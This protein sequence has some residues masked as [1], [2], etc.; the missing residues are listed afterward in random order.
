MYLEL[1]NV[2]YGLGVLSPGGGVRWG[3]IQGAALQ[4]QYGLQ[5]G[6][7]HLVLETTMPGIRKQYRVAAIYTGM[8]PTQC[9]F[10]VGP[11]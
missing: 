4:P 1:F 6:A 10:S 11:L 8:S 7:H 5:P 2:L 9:Y 3:A